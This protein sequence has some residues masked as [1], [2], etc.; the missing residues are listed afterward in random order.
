M[1]AQV[2]VAIVGLV[3]GVIVALIQKGRKE[4]KTDHN[5]VATL[6]MNVHDDVVKIEDKLDHVD[7]VLNSHIKEHKVTN[8]TKTS[9]AENLNKK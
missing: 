3:G 8:I 1:E 5:I 2:V 6:L 9:K 4:N 7:K